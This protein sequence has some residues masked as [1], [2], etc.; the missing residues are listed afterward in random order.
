MET[1]GGIFERV[2]NDFLDKFSHV[3]WKDSRL[4]ITTP[5]GF[6][7]N[8]TATL[9]CLT[10][11]YPYERY[12]R[13]NW[14]GQDLWRN[15]D[16]VGV[17]LFDLYFH[18]NSN[19]DIHVLAKLSY[20]NPHG[21]YQDL[22]F[23]KLNPYISNYFVP[24][25][26]VREKMDEI[27][28][29]YKIDYGNTVGLWYRGTDK[30]T[31]HPPVPPH[32]YV[33]EI[34]KLVR[35]NPRL[36]VLVQTDQEQVRDIFVRELGEQ[37]FYLNELPVTKSSIGIHKMSSEERGLS[38]FEF[39]VMLLAVVNMFAKCKH[40]I[41]YTGS[42]GLWIYLYRGNANN[43]CQLRPRLPDLISQYEDENEVPTE[44]MTTQRNLYSSMLEE[45]NYVLRSESI[46]LSAIRTSFM[47]RSMKCLAMK[48]DR[49][50]PDNTTRGRFRKRIVVALRPK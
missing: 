24:S 35:K 22:N 36:R 31:E 25:E 27:V 10:R 11:I 7:A 32:Y 39:G 23:E 15:A 49:L 47:Y 26:I 44:R 6:F 1:S 21:V 30:F 19:F 50:F 42:I 17:N 29:K 12:V 14:P 33:A 18:P 16:Q 28:H 5:S 20:T 9:S 46:E 43:T 41:T 2:G 37:V 34:R 48:I 3:D 4:D 38:N 45:E 13:V 40:V 8:C